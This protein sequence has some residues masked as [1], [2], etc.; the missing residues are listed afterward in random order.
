M[1]TKNVYLACKNFGSK[2]SQVQKFLGEC[3]ISEL[4]FRGKFKFSENA[5]VDVPSHPCNS[6]NHSR[7][8]SGF[9]RKSAQRS[10]LCGKEIRFRVVH[11]STQGQLPQ[12]FT[13]IIF[14]IPFLCNRG[15]FFETVQHVKEKAIV[16][17]VGEESWSSL[18][19][20]CQ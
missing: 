17:E 20:A 5:A 2:L 1:R 15:N 19:T 11:D 13:G 12:F 14:F 3:V 9:R 4:V 10:L 16:S 7:G 6:G 18:H 8:N